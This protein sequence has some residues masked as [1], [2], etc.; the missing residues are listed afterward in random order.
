MPPRKSPSVTSLFSSS[1]D[2]GDSGDD[3]VGHTNG[4]GVTNKGS[5]GDAVESFWSAAREKWERSRE[6]DSKTDHK[7][8]FESSSEE[9]EAA[10]EGE[11]C[12]LHSVQPHDTLSG[13]AL[14]YGVSEGDIQAAN[15][16]MLNNRN[17]FSFKTLRIPSGGGGTEGGIDDFGGIAGGPC[18]ELCWEPLGEE[19]DLPA[20]GS[21]P[22]DAHAERRDAESNSVGGEKTRTLDLRHGVSI[23]VHVACM[24]CCADSCLADFSTWSDDRIRTQCFLVDDQLFCDEHGPKVQLCSNHGKGSGVNECNNRACRSINS[25][26]V[27]DCALCPMVSAGKLPECDG[28]HYVSFVGLAGPGCG[29]DG[30]RN[31]PYCVPS[32]S[33]CPCLE[34]KPKASSASSTSSSSHRRRTSSS[35]SLPP[36][37]KQQEQQQQ[38]LAAAREVALLTREFGEALHAIK[39]EPA[40][41]QEFLAGG[42]EVKCVDVFASATRPWL[43]NLNGGSKGWIWKEGDDL[44]K[45]A[46]LLRVMDALNAIWERASLPVRCNTYRVVPFFIDGTHCGFIEA[47]DGQ[48][49]QDQPVDSYQVLQLA[50]EMGAKGNRFVSTL[51]G[52]IIASYLFDLFDR[53]HGNIFL[54]TTGALSHIDFNNCFGLMTRWEPAPK[55]WCTLRARRT[56]HYFGYSTR[57][58]VD[59]CA[60]GYRE[61]SRH[62]NSG[63]ILRAF[64]DAAVEVGLPAETT[65]PWRSYLEKVISPEHAEK[66][67]VELQSSLTTV[68]YQF[69]RVLRDNVQTF[70]TSFG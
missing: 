12:F 46:L 62:P 27:A 37:Q 60:A 49:L 11:L 8:L 13:L 29:N 6:T 44:R 1:G 24:R 22:G 59:T 39:E 45:D 20:S 65:A 43:L 51:N 10:R 54:D 61:L 42:V 55:V 2:S 68:R 16:S 41:G 17:V 57:M 64:D 19:G 5:D 33:S 25:V 67:S 63:E 69:G 36:L 40:K 4:D 50:K 18:C 34:G 48:P 66:F 70:K 52:T 3:D 31:R 7:K 30:C 58:I 23:L 21:T 47:L 56:A 53:H 35:G 14:R 9:E 38:Q 26:C 28:S 15:G 32:C